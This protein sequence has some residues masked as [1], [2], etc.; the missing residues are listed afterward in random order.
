MSGRIAVLADAVN[1][2]PVDGGRI[3]LQRVF[4]F[5]PAMFTILHIVKVEDSLCFIILRPAKLNLI[6]AVYFLRNIIQ[7]ADDVS[8]FP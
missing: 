7:D 4:G 5:L 1:D 6:G 8:I 2:V 3:F